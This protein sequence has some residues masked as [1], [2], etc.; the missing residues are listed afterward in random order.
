MTS[1]SE[2]WRESVWIVL[3]C[4]WGLILLGLLSSPSP[5]LNGAQVGGALILVALFAV[6]ERRRRGS[7]EDVHLQQWLTLGTVILV[8]ATLDYSGLRT[9]GIILNVSPLVALA[10]AWLLGG[11]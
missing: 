11:R 10:L 6:L 7:A 4:N 2:G 3:F 8:V 9:E 1:S 5:R